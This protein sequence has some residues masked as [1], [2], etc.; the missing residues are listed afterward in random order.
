MKNQVLLGDYAL[1]KDGYLG[2]G[3]FA[4]VF[5]GHRISDN[6]P[7]AI[8]V[9]KT[10]K[11]EQQYKKNLDDEVAILRRMNHENILKLYDV[12]ERKSKKETEMCLMTELC[13]G[14]LEEVINENSPVNEEVFK[15]YL[16]DISFHL[17]F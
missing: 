8:K 3:S 12:Y 10:S 2:K 17:F 11:L 4:S 16:R 1:H 7:V 9:V 6:L 5:K 15:S 14:T 13:E